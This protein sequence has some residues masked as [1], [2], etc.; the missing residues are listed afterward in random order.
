MSLPLSSK[1]PRGRRRTWRPTAPPG[2]S[3]SSRDLFWCPTPTPRRRTLRR[4]IPQLPADEVDVQR[5]VR[6]HGIVERVRDVGD[7][8]RV[9]EEAALGDAVAAR[10]EEAGLRRD[11]DELVEVVDIEMP[12]GAEEVVE[13]GGGRR[14]PQVRVR[15][16]HGPRRHGGAPRLEERGRRLRIGAGV[17][18]ARIE[19]EVGRREAHDAPAARGQE[20]AR[21]GE[22]R[23]GRGAVDV[24]DEVLGEDPV[25][26]TGAERKRQ[27]RVV[28]EKV[29]R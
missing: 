7:V 4:S 29:A 13:Q 6:F 1:P 5:L 25:E 17:Q 21:L 9:V 22:E 15:A 14:G 19:S 23:D 18:A 24:L 27:T 10:R 20:S 12:V 8:A 2:S 16:R 3:S 11:R 26:G 28:F